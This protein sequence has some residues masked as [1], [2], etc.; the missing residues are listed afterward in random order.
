MPNNVTTQE[1]IKLRNFNPKKKH[2]RLGVLYR[3]TLLVNV[4]V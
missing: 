1:N 4:E 2:L 3:S